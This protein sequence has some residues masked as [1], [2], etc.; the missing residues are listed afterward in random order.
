VS[1]LKDKKFWSGILTAIITAVAG[2][3]G[4][5]QV[6]SGG[7]DVDVEVHVPEQNHTHRNW[8]MDINRALS[9]HVDE[10]H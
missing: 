10:Y 2:Y 4:Y 1:V 7:A 6:T 5:E 8:H 9:D 3:F